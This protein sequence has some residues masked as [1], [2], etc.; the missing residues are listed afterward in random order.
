MINFCSMGMLVE[1]LYDQEQEYIPESRE[2]LIFCYSHNNYLK[3]NLCQSYVQRQGHFSVQFA[4]F[5]AR[6]SARDQSESGDK[7]SEYQSIRSTFQ[8][9]PPDEQDGLI[10]DRIPL[11]KKEAFCLWLIFSNSIIS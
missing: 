11:T 3:L 1:T 7:D 10:F 6:W 2:D 9:Y 5:S 4:A 8:H